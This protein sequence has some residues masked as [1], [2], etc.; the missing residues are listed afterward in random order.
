MDRDLNAFRVSGD[1]EEGGETGQC[2]RPWSFAWLHFSKFLSFHCIFYNPGKKTLYSCYDIYARMAFLVS[3]SVQS[4]VDMN[5][6][7]IL[8][9]FSL[10]AGLCSLM[11]PPN[12]FNQSLALTANGLHFPSAMSLPSVLIPVCPGGPFIWCIHICSLF[13]PELCLWHSFVLALHS[14]LLTRSQHT[15][16]VIHRV[17]LCVWTS[18]ASVSNCGQ[19][20]F[21]TRSTVYVN[22]FA[23]ILHSRVVSLHFSCAVVFACRVPA[24]KVL[25]I[26]P[27]VLRCERY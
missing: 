9:S 1:S 20:S 17:A 3:W 24:Q 22:G 13:H 6:L 8:A 4:S 21:P 5:H 16:A 10:E 25:W 12:L 18:V 27:S 7:I 23:V 26:M 2:R 19:F 11:L 15:G 14:L